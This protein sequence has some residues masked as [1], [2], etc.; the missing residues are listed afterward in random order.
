M[1]SYL[2]RGEDSF[3]V[4]GNTKR[5]KVYRIELNFYEKMIMTKDIEISENFL[6]EENT[7]SGVCS[8]VLLDMRIFSY[9]CLLKGLSLYVYLISR[10][11][12]PSL[13]GIPFPCDEK[14]R[15]SLPYGK[16]ILSGRKRIKITSNTKIYSILVLLR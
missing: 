6:P 1:L 4:I 15:N 12:A 8:P 2:Y 9:F 3:F 13:G 10:L 7:V 11:E 14:K 5:E 16:E